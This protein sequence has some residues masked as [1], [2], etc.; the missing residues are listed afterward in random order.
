MKKPI[1]VLISLLLIMGLVTAC[2]AAPASIEAP[3]EAVEEAVV[4]EAV[5][6]EPTPEP[7]EAPAEEEAM[8]EAEA[9]AEEMSESM[10]ELPM[11][12]PLSVTGDVISA[13][14]STV[15]PLAERMAE[16]FQEEGYSGQITIDSIGSGAGFSRFCEAGETDVSNASRP[17]REEEIAN[18]GAIDREPIEFRV[19]TD[20]LAVSV[21]QENDFVDDVTM[22]ELAAI[23]ST[24]ET[25]A[26]VR[27]EWPAEPIQRFIPGTDSGTFDYFV[28]EV[29]DEDEEPILGASNLQ[30]S[31]D[32]NV[33]VQ[34]IAGSP[35]AIGFFGYAYYQENQD[36][37]R[38]LAVDGVEPTAESA[39]DNSYPLSRPLFI[40][41]DAGI[42]QGKPQVA[43]YV[44]FFLTYVND[45]IVDVGYFPSSGTAL[46]EAKQKW[47][48]AMEA[49]GAMTEASGGGEAAMATGELPMVDPLN[50][51]GDV[52]SAGSSTV[53]PLAER[54]AERFQEEGYSGQ[55]T[56]DSIGSGAGF[57]R[58]CE[59][60]ET[61]VSNASRPIREEEIANCGAIDREPIEFRVGTD[62]LAV[63]VS[64]ENDFVDDVT[65]EELAAIFS[66]AETWADVRAEW[67]A[68]PIQRFIP[69]TDSGTFDYFVE[70]VFDEDEEPILGA[71]NL[72][73]SEDD[74]VLVQG[75]A[76]SPYAI[77]FFGYAYYQENQDVIRALA[78]DGVEPTAESAEDNSYPLS[79]PLFIYSDAGI[80]QGKPQVAAY[81]NFFLTY[82]NDEIVDVGYFP[83]S[84]A[85]LGQRRLVG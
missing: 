47:L 25:W 42:M 11:V 27:A 56:I 85:A 81:V 71:S 24:A 9:P 38:A 74:N 59:A 44:N 69:G 26:D 45:E 64:Q 40:Y 22:E 68:E 43:A 80:M 61:D 78:V 30:L 33:L 32:D 28:E 23:F 17:I 19:G 1:L 41:S 14:S 76:G 37:I 20:A 31:E 67:P 34:G 50:V 16:R 8:A 73:L 29:F 53:F 57:S 4:E 7:T 21:S 52:I 51:T 49:E 15:F 72:Q 79:R 60:G 36:V 48:D 46:D 82:V 66:T 39:E 10:L 84:D 54:M 2:G 6:D 55:I 65:M 63:S 5:A 62:A 75:I 77:G 3:A 70:E 58:F 18:C 83:A 13:G 35:Y 12:D